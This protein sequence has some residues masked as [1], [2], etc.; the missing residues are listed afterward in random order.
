VVQKCTTFLA[1]IQ[2]LP[3]LLLTALTTA[4][5]GY[6]M[7]PGALIYLLGFMMQMTSMGEL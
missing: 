7:Q 2:Q 3:S 6:T 4:Y 5:A 1:W